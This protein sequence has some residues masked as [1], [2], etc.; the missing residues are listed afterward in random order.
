MPNRIKLGL[1]GVQKWGEHVGDQM[2]ASKV[3]SPAW[4]FDVNTAA[5]NQAAEKWKATPARSLSE[6][7]A[8]EVAGVVIV[9]PNH[10]H[11]ELGQA[12]AAAGKHAMIIKPLANSVADSRELVAAFARAN[13]F[14]A[15]GHPARKSPLSLHVKGLLD[16]GKLGQVVLLAAV[17]G[18]NGGMKK[19]PT[20]WRARREFAPGGPLIQLVVHTFDTW[21]YWF[22]PIVEVQAAGG[23]RA[24]P[25]DNDDFFAGQVRFADGLIGNFATQY[26]APG[27]GFDAVYGTERTVVLSGDEPFEVRRLVS[28]PGGKPVWPDTERQELSFEPTDTN[29]LDIEDFARDILAGRQPHASGEDGLRAVAC[30]HAA[31]LSRDRGGAWVKVEEV[32]AS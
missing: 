15:T 30:V 9:T 6:L 14:L 11:L 8:S 32:M 19:S 7:L 25:G 17:L 31:L 16:A 21:Q 12:V 13:R 3:V 28:P 10:T 5:A 1:I 27:V 29:R 26:A 22:G 4:V 18:H 20:D 23:H 24:T 2:A